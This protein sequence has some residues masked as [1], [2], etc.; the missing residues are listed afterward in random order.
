MDCYHHFRRPL[1]IEVRIQIIN[2]PEERGDGNTK[3]LINY[4]GG[5]S[6]YTA[7]SECMA[8]CTLVVV[9]YTYNI[10]IYVYK[11]HAAQ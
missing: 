5:V 10:Y 9:A 7:C 3:I 11:S 2:G 1:S 4:K 6:L 8:V